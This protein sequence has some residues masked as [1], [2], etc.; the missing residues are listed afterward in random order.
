MHTSGLVLHDLLAIALAH[1]A[2]DLHLA[3][4]APPKMRVQGLLQTMTCPEPMPTTVCANGS[5]AQ[6][7]L[8]HPLTNEFVA[9]N[10]ATQNESR[11]LDAISTRAR[12]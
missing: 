4:N 6:A 7:T 3:S 11:H 8:N 10:A 1:H 5:E 2:S 9:P 12:S